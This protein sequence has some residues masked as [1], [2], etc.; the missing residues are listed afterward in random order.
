MRPDI[1]TTDIPAAGTVVRLTADAGLD[2]KD[3]ILWCSFQARDGNTGIVYVGIADVTSTH[4]WELHP[5]VTEYEGRPLVLNPGAYGGSIAAGDIYFD[6]A[7][8]GDD[9][10]W[11]LILDQ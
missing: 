1:G 4:G 8:N 5:T 6:A 7:T 9:V 10:D 11:A 2:V 3:R